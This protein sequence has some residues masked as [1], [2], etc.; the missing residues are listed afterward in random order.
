M[1]SQKIKLIFTF[2]L[3][4]ILCSCAGYKIVPT[5][6][7]NLNN[8]IVVRIP[9]IKNNTPFVDAGAIF[10]IEIIKGLALQGRYKVKGGSPDKGDNILVGRLVSAKNPKTIK[11]NIEKRFIGSSSLQ[12]SIG[13]RGG[14]YI[15][16]SYQTNFRLEFTYIGRKE[17]SLKR[18][19]LKQFSIPVSFTFVN[20][21]K[22]ITDGNKEGLTNFTNNHASMKYVLQ[23]V[24]KGLVGNIGSH[25]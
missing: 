9:M 22:S 19:V 10:T 2:L 25:L 5:V 23:Q 4:A 3:T 21:I 18:S 14:F 1:I 24:A 17:G 8:N 15:P 16:L 13:D 12:E 6:G 7:S 11:Q 20:Q